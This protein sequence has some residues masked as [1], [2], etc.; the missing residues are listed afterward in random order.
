MHAENQGQAKANVNV[1]LQ[2]FSVLKH[3]SAKAY[4][5]LEVNLLAFFKVATR[6]GRELNF[7]SRKLQISG[8][9]LPIVG[10]SVGLETQFGCGGQVTV[11]FC[12]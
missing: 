4:N 2:L 1:K 9:C 7:I 5:V 10:S 8:E 6:Q 11:I 12:A 3:H